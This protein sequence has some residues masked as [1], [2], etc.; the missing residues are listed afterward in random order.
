MTR[1]VVGLP[2]IYIYIVFLC[3]ISP[4]FSQQRIEILVLD[5]DTETP[6]SG[7]SIHAVGTDRG[8][9]TDT[10]GMAL[11]VSPHKETEVVF[12]LMGYRT[13]AQKLHADSTNII[14]LESDAHT[15]EG[16]SVSVK[17][18]YSNRNN[19]A[20]ELIDRVIRNKYKNRLSGQ[21]HIRFEQ[22]DKLKLGMLDP[23]PF[24]RK[25]LASLN[26][27]FDD[28]DTV[29]V[30]GKRLL[31][32]Y[33]EESKSNVY[34]QKAPSRFKK[35]IHQQQKTEFNPRYVN[36]PNI[37]SY[38]N[39][40]FQPVDIYDESI[41][42]MNKLVLSPIADN[43]K[44]YYRYY[45]ADTIT[46]E[47]G[48]FIKLD[49]EPRNKEDLL[50]NG[51]LMVSMDGSYAVK[52]AD[53]HIGKSANLNWI[54]EAHLSLD[55]SPNTD[56]IMLLDTVKMTMSFGV[57]DR[58]ALHGER[59]SVHSNYDLSG[60]FDE[61]VFS[62][63]PI[64]VSRDVAT[65]MT[66]RP[67]ALTPFET[68]TYRDMERLKTDRNFN[69][70]LS[71]GYL[72]AQ[73][74]Y[75]LDKFELGPIEYL[76]SRNNVEG[77]RL[78][79]G[80]RSTPSLS[81]K[82]FMEGYLAYGDLDN[83]LKYFLR[84]AVSLNGESVAEFPAH[85][86]EGTVQHDILDP[87]RAINFHRGDSFFESFRRNRPTKWFAT[88]AYRLRH[89]VEFGNHV[90]ITTGFTHTRRQTVGD[91]RL[92]SSGDPEEAVA[93]MNTNE[94]HVV[95][96]WA[97]YEK[98]YYR[99][100]ERVN[101][102]EKYP[103]FS[104]EYN[105]GL[106]G[107]W[108]GQYDYDKLSA[109]I[110]KRFFLNQL[111]FADMTVTGGKIWGTLPYTLLYMPNVKVEK[112]RHEVSYDLMNSM[113]F[114]ADEYIKVGFE[115]QLQGF[116]LNKIPLLK[117]LRLR[118]IWGAQLFYGRMGEHNNPL[119]SDHVVEFDTDHDGHALTHNLGGVPYWEGSVGLDNILRILK[120][121]YVRRFTHINFPNVNKDRYRVTLSI[122]F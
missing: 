2:C 15:I 121:E 26:T 65:D 112:N 10:N 99:N 80:G 36:N 109:S 61:S 34:S 71:I 63:S 25:S 122:N 11:L 8:V 67:L 115:H 19:P 55:Y 60:Q 119:N 97:P 44:I 77:N 53:L 3:A 49:F 75:N 9:S 106:K 101:I 1:R 66:D 59:I 113:E 54:N 82:V 111:G 88:D 31:S 4:V 57:G 118:E 103:V 48:R 69:A 90:S 76:Y 83:K 91:F 20:V 114:A 64:E 6:L 93:N 43:G 7:V 38:L 40:M 72:I 79:L 81:E 105:K 102:V 47:H 42:M 13:V 45:I 33:L 22:Y 58:D 37:Q 85:Y 92:I 18:R 41:F 52:E 78:R 110:S 98:F 39:F 104:V 73:S 94:A 32:L 107:F 17:R 35:L 24:F 29:S 87:G 23:T 28:L 70:A 56:G 100:L 21:A 14:Y 5:E 108:E 96:R 120:V 74:Y 95:L 30:P 16:I 50:F 116:I 51:S 68:K 117:R 12:R 62:G 46:N 89:V 86:L 27:M 84:T